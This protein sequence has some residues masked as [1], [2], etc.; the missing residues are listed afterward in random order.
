MNEETKPRALIV[1]DM[2]GVI[3]DVSRS[4]REAVRMAARLFFKGAASWENLPDPLFSLEELAR[5]KQSGGLNND[6]D[7]TFLIINL[8]FTRIQISIKGHDPNPWSNYK[9]TI[10][11]ADVSG[12]AR[13]LQEKR[14][15]LSTLFDRRGRI[16][17]DF[18]TS[19]YTGDVGSGNIIKQIFQEIYLGKALFES[20]YQVQSIVFHEKGLIDRE[21]LLI[22]KSTLENLSS[23]NILAI[24]TGRPRIE[25]DYPL[26]LF[27][28]KKYFTY[29]LT[30]DDCINEEEKRFKKSG[31]KVSLSKPNPFML[32]AIAGA[33]GNRVSGYYYVGDM[34]DDMMAASNSDSGFIG[35]G[36]LKS[37]SAKDQ[38]GKDLERAGADHIIEDFDELAKIVEPTTTHVAGGLN[39]RP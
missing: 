8:L 32:D 18:I 5:V 37:S 25:A 1:F 12:L 39:F 35:I 33:L 24:A 6:W 13:F 23:R 17:N 29:I 27:N 34:P 30:L 20:T 4:Y 11:R 15:P 21:T 2:D 19:L 38:L 3:I 28:L 9:K 36:M 16:S 7:L 26:G 10:K 31:K 14:N 22:D